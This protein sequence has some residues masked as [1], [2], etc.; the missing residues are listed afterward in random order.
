MHELGSILKVLAVASD[1]AVK[2]LD[3]RFL[4]TVSENRVQAVAYTKRLK[5]P[6][7]GQPMTKE[8]WPMVSP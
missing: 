2:M 7:R 6:N 4:G 1:L 5:V 8:Y 3:V